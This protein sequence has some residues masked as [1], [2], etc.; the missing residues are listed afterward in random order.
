MGE[1][2]HWIATDIKIVQSSSDSDPASSRDFHMYQLQ[3]NQASSKNI[4]ELV[5]YLPP[6]P[7]PKTG[8]HRYVF[9]LLASSEE[10]ESSELR[11]PK[12]RPHWGYG[13]VG[14]GVR[15]WA[16]DNGLVAVGKLLHPWDS[17]ISKL[18]NSDTRRELLLCS[19][20]KAVMDISEGLPRLQ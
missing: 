12:E 5:P 7:P 9:V 20:Q 18:P 19:K 3:L 6:S 11:K 1:M 16:E 8:S 15:D 4:T 10:S 14:R 17:N 2:C 13:K